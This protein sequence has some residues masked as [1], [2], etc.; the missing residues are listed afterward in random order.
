[1]GSIK[2]K[3]DSS[4]M[5]LGDYYSSA[6]RQN[7]LV[8]ADGFADTETGGLDPQEVEE[9]IDE[10]M[11]VHREEFKG[12]PG[13]QGPKGEGGAS[14]EELEKTQDGLS[15]IQLFGYYIPFSMEARNYVDET[16]GMMHRNVKRADLSKMSWARSRFGEHYFFTSPLTDSDK[17]YTA[18]SQ[19]CYCTTYKT[20]KTTAYTDYDDKTCGVIGYSATYSGVF[21]RDDEYEDPESFSKAVSGYIYYVLKEEEL[22]TAYGVPDLQS[23]LAAPWFNTQN[24]VS[25]D[26]VIDENAIYTCNMNNFNT[27]PKDHHTGDHPYWV[28]SR[29]VDIARGGSFYRKQTTT[30]SG[31]YIYLASIDKRV[32]YAIARDTQ[33]PSNYLYTV[34]IIYST[35]NGIYATVRHNNSIIN[36]REVTIEYGIVD[37]ID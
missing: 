13:E 23:M 29:M 24:Y 35:G 9:M 32:V 5:K 27:R 12:D 22:T 30:G 18:Y 2:T 20:S 28:K 6:K 8:G 10:Y 14:Q 33:A 21:I 26:I 1:M 16:D 15:Q 17:N 36:N 34:D 11:E 25:G 4:G 7:L 19:D 3:N 37:A 31:Q